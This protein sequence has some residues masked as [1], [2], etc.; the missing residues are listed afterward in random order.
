MTPHSV[1][2]A[3]TAFKVKFAARPPNPLVVP[4]RYF[5]E[6]SRDV[7]VRGGGWAATWHVPLVLAALSAVFLF[8]AWMSLRKMQ[9]DA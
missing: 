3:N 7:F 5:V 6:V 2:D 4:A 9:I 1:S 8:R